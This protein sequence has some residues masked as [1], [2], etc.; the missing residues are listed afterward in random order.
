MNFKSVLFGFIFLLS[1]FYAQAQLNFDGEFR[2]RSILN[3]GYKVPV[4]AGSEAVL[5]V[6]Q[7]SRIIMNYNT[8]TYRT[9][10]TLQDARVWGGDDVFNPSGIMGNTASLGIYEAWVELKMKEKSRLR[11]GRQEWNY[12]DMRLLAWRNWW[13][14]GHSY[15]G[16]LYT[17]HDHGTGWFIDMGLSYNNN[18]NRIGEVNPASWTGEKLKT[19]NFLIFKKSFSPR[20]AL[21]AAFLVSGR[22]LPGNDDLLLTGT[23]GLVLDYNKG[24]G[25]GAGVFGHFEGYYQHGKDTRELASGDFRNISAYLL[26]G[27][28]GYRAP[29]KKWEIAGGAEIISGHDYTNTD[30]GYLET[31]HSFDL[32]YG[33]RFVHYGGYMN[34]F[35]MQESPRGGTKGGGYIDPYLRFGFKPGKKSAVDL[36]WYSPFLSTPVPAHLSI[37]PETGKPVGTE[38]DEQ[39]NTVYWEG[40]LG[41]YL[42]I[43]YTRRINP[44]IVVKAGWSLGSV[45]DLKNQMVY[46]YEDAGQSELHEMGTNYFGWVMLIVKPRFFTTE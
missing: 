28:L 26:T 6:D 41:S 27:E 37:H 19:L 14:S 17:M 10:F 3:H 24:A 43:G 18:G 29:Q 34:H 22:D 13:T 4:K 11:I 32:L 45:S 5:S 21:S 35:T 40:S 20:L 2:T 25:A 7:R 42:D 9:R 1:N 44:D 30:A 12:H 39:G 38:T 33:A 36:T 23:H 46:G 16:L 31:R 15:D 8:S